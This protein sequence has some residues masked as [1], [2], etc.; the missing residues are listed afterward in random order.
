[1]DSRAKSHLQVAKQAPRH[2]N[3][4]GEPWQLWVQREKLTKDIQGSIY[5]AVHNRESLHYWETKRDIDPDGLQTIDWPAIG[6]AMQAL[7]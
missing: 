3:I 1:M 7:P 2:H 5:S 6:K 4:E